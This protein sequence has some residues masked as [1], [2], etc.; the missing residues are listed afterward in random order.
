M[1]FL[2][3]YDFV[4]VINDY[5]LLILYSFVKTQREFSTSNSLC[6]T[7]ELKLWREHRVLDR[8]YRLNWGGWIRAFGGRYKRVYKKTGRERYQAKQHIFLTRKQCFL[9]DKLV[10]RKWKKP[11]H[12]VGPD[13]DIYEP[14]HKRTNSFHHPNHRTFYPWLQI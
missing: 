12:Y 8:F 11:H 4:R 1:F 3:Y 14:Y 7:K 10:S 6:T 2:L 9:M 5:N 13:M